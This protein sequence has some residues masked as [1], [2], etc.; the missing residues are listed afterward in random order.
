VRKNGWQLAE[1][2]KETAAVR[3]QADPTARAARGAAGAQD[4]HSHPA[5]TWS[6]PGLDAEARRLLV[7]LVW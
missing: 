6:G 1:H 5:R 7:G 4:C 3:A 2:A